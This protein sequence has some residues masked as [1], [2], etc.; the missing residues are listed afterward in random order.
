MINQELENLRKLA[1]SWNNLNINQLLFITD[2]SIV[3]ESQWVLFPIEGKEQ[4]LNYLKT[5]FDSIKKEMHKEIISLYAEIAMLP[6]L[7][8]RQCIVLTQI[9]INEIRKV[10]ILIKNSDKKINRIDVCFVPRPDEAILSGEI[11]K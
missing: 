5:K 1:Q 7:E 8:N 11:P 9:T 6:K 10:T 2:D 3:Y 4:F